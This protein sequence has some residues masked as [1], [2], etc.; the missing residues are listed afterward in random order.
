MESEGLNLPD[1]FKFHVIVWQRKT[2]LLSRQNYFLMVFELQRFIEIL[3]KIS[4]GLT[5]I[6]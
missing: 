1:I 5:S 4:P 2:A 6:K 3:G